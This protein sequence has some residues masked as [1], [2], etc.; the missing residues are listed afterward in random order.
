MIRAA[1]LL[2]LVL[3]CAASA[4]SLAD[5]PL[6][7]P[8]PILFEVRGDETNAFEL[9]QRILQISNVPFGIEQ[10]P[11]AGGA[12]GPAG[13]PDRYERIEAGTIREAL[14]RLAAADP[15]YAWEETDGRLIVRAAAFRGGA[16][17]LDRLCPA[18]SIADGSISAIL[19]GLM[20]AIDP[21]RPEG[22]IGH[23]ALGVSGGAGPGLAPAVRP[24]AAPASETS[25]TTTPAA[26]KGLTFG[27]GTCLQA[28]NTIAAARGLSWTVR[29]EG[30]SFAAENVGIALASSGGS[31]MA[32]SSRMLRSRPAV[33]DPR[34][35]DRLPSGLGVA[36]MLSIY[37][38][39][40]KV[41]FGLEMLPEPAGRTPA[42]TD[43]AVE[44]AGVSPAEAVDRIV[45][46]DPRL[47][48][49]DANG[50]FSIRPR[51]DLRGTTPLDHPVASFT[52]EGHTVDRVLEHVA[53]LLGGTAGGSGKG[54]G[55]RPGTPEWE[56]MEKERAK[57]VS[58]TLHGTTLRGILDEL[59]RV[60]GT[61]SWT[62]RVTEQ[63]AR[64]VFVSIDASSWDGWS[65][66]RGVQ[67]SA[68]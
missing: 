33:R 25:P 53:A 61:L 52:A 66:S 20:R 26:S 44:I 32:L 7:A 11:L 49:S 31:T 24:P 13:P 14:D 9:L 2:L 62:V 29:H 43:G 22:G 27:G 41:R 37:A 21:D 36:G 47:T 15:R 28:L 34:R 17:L 30:T 65:V 51:S 8:M 5:A 48:W 58:F 46:A 10:A 18:F 45:G 12:A 63:P 39:T 1:C 16:G 42:R 6:Q 35:P 64:G 57:R 3:P 19:T 23:S 55:A 68:W 54:G 60:Q 56:R 50:I 38:Q 59:C 40:S 4:Q 67:L